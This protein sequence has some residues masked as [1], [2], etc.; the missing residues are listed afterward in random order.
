MTLSPFVFGGADGKTRN[1]Q[2]FECFDE[3]SPC[4]LEQ[5]S[6]CVIKDSTDKATSAMDAQQKYVPW[7]ICM[8]TDGENKMDAALCSKTVGLNYADIS[9][10]QKT[11]GVNLLKQLEKHMLRF[12][13]RPR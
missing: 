13:K 12:T 8:D 5:I 10:C 4:V 1:S 2:G 11:D 9:S 7:L 3:A 6:A